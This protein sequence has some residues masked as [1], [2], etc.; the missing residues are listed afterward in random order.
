MMTLYLICA[1]GVAAGS[2][3]TRVDERGS[4]ERD[5]RREAA[6]GGLSADL[7]RRRLV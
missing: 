7:W 6:G 1:I 2:P 3:G 4:L 5:D